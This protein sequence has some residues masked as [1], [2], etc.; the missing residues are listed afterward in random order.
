MELVKTVQL[1][2]DLRITQRTVLRMYA[3]ALEIGV[4]GKMEHAEILVM[5]KLLLSKIN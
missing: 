3:S 1:I 2:Q 5:V 4:I